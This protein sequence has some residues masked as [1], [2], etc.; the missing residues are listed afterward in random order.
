MG[1]A[2][3]MNT[4][5][6]LREVL[7]Q[8]AADG[9]VLPDDFEDTLEDMN[10]V[11]LETGSPWYVR[12]FVGISAW[13]AAILLIVFLFLT[14]IISP[15]DGGVVFG[16]VFCAIAVGLN[17]LG[18]RNDFLAQLGLA[19]S[20]TGQILF[21]IG[22]FDLSD[23]ELVPTALGLMFLEIILLWLYHDRLHRVIST[24]AIPGAILA[25]LL[26]QDMMAGVHIL[27]LALGAGIVAIQYKESDLL[28]ARLDE[29]I[30]PVSYGVAIFLLGLL[31]LP[32]WDDFDVHWWI[33]A[34]LLLAIL[35][36]LVCL[37]VADLGLGLLSGA[38][39]WLV[40]GCLILLIP[41]VRTP[42]ILGAL[43]IL[44][45]GFWRNNRLIIGLS[46]LFLV[47]YL[48]AYYYSLEWTLLVKSFALMGTGAI[49]FVLRYIL[50][51]FTRGVAS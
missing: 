38:V 45:L 37:I 30:R 19:L 47:F 42:G 26:E 41:A 50:L 5:L 18:P 20:L 43:I 32:M 28:I 16:L 4:D 31:I 23:Y 24:L 17:R 48:G 15:E 51:K 2:K 21:M 13:I 39:P 8:L 25:I 14:N 36:I 3:R 9:F 10:P 40:A 1:G 34:V 22:L 29:L 46:A 35:V 27:T 6:T 33:T 12:L 44:L 11:K 49:L 7:D